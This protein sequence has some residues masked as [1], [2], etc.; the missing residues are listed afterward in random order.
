MIET[1]LYPGST[2]LLRVL[3]ERWRQD[4]GST[5]RTWFLWDERLKNFRSIRRG[6]A[7]VVEEIGG[8][9]F[10]N[11]YRGSSLETIVGSIAEQ[12]RS[13][14]EPITPSYGNRSFGS[15]TSMRMPEISGLSVNSCI[16]VL[17]A[18]PSRSSSK[19]STRSID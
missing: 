12:G 18:V 8:G 16:T 2:D 19:E 9:T 3:I 5:Y 11:V 10:G 17:A 6:I 14:K 7:Q 13:S 15:R 4:P 1:M